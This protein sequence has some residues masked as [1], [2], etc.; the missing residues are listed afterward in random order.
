MEKKRIIKLRTNQGLAKRI[1]F[2]NNYDELIEKTKSFLPIDDNSN[3]YQFID[4][5][6]DREIRHQED[7]ELMSK[8]YENEKTIKILVNIIKKEELEE[9]PLSHVFS[10][11]K[12][13]EE[14]INISITPNLENNEK[15]E[16]EPE[17]KIKK[18]IQ[19]LVRSKMKDLENNIIQ[20]IYKSIKTQLNINEERINTVNLNQKEIIHKDIFCNNCSMENIKGIRYKCAQCPNFNLCDNCEKYCQHDNNHIFIKIRKPLKEESELINKINQDL[21]YKNNEYNYTVNLKDIK[22]NIDNKNNDTL[23][24]QITLKNNGNE[25]WKAGAVFKCLPDSQI[26]GNDSKI[27]CK[28]NK[29]ATVNIELIFDNNKDKLIPSINEYY[30]Y[31]QMFNS[32]NEAF[33]NITKFRVI[34]QN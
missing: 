7:F 28:V 27:E 4:E 32:N 5:K 22:I 23:V 12:L 20:D 19:E 8:S 26:K 18:D 21:K 6:V 15:I 11:N 13:N 2:P 17:D 3:R 33:G 9:I 31:Y 29:D 30:V 34:F 16:D 25:P 14:S 24:Q 10:Q 1:D